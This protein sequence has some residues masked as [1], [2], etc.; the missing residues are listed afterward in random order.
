MI[1]AEGPGGS[2]PEGSPLDGTKLGPSERFRSGRQVSLLPIGTVKFFKDRVGWGFIEG[3]AGTDIFVYYR[4]IVGD[5]H[6]TLVKGERVQFELIDGPKGAR[7]VNVV[8]LD[9]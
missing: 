7:A 2:N 9:S 3:E 1:S 8:R 5:G 6:R 4:D